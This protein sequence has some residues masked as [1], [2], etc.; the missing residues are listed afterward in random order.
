M[1]NNSINS[2]FAG[3]ENAENRASFSDSVLSLIRDKSVTVDGYKYFTLS[4]TDWEEKY[5]VIVDDTLRLFEKEFNRFKTHLSL[6][7]WEVITSTSY[8]YGFKNVTCVNEMLVYYPA[9]FK[10][11]YLYD[12]E[13]LINL[14]NSVLF[15]LNIQ[16]EILNPS[17]AFRYENVEAMYIAHDVYE[18]DFLECGEEED[19]LTEE[20]FNAFVD[21]RVN[22]HCVNYSLVWRGAEQ[23]TNGTIYR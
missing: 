13:G 4:L 11:S 21:S 20:E 3:I 9:D 10:L 5:S 18:G 12:F 22:A 17:D 19:E 15:G 23:V 6:S 1:T 16:A 14:L 8:A 7:D 2:A